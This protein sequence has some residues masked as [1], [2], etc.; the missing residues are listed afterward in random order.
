MT[1]APQ[2]HSGLDALK[3]D[4]SATV[5]GLMQ[6]LE[7]RR[8]YRKTVSE[9]RRLDTRQLADLGMHRSEISRVARETVYGAGR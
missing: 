1:Y 5:Y 2:T 9:L 3:L 7:E 8:S 6:R 4:I